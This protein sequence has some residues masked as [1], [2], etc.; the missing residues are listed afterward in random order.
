MILLLAITAPP[1]LYPF[2]SLLL[3][4]CCRSTFRCCKHIDRPDTC[5]PNEHNSEGPYSYYDSYPYRERDSGSAYRY[6][7]RP[8]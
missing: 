6:A 2:M 7:F 4:P 5:L 8:Q 3:L 1:H